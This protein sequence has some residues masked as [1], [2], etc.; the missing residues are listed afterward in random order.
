M[1]IHKH[2]AVFCNQK[3]TQVFAVFFTAC[4]PEKNVYLIFHISEI[5]QYNN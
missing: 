5:L 2:F 4:L 3:I 1:R